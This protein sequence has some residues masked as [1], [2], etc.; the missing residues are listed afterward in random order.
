MNFDFIIDKF[1]ETKLVKGF[2]ECPDCPPP[3][4]CDP[5][6]PC[7]EGGN[8]PGPCPC[9]DGDGGGAGGGGGPG[10]VFGEVDTQE[11]ENFLMAVGEEASPCP[12][13]DNCGPGGGGGVNVYPGFLPQSPQGPVPDTYP[14]GPNPAVPPLNWPICR[15][16]F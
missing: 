8:P 11:V 5:W 9:C 16:T 6:T 10:P 12:D 4:P 7:C 15:I 3:D 2:P 14:S 1:F 13:C